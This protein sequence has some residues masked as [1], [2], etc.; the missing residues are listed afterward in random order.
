MRRYL[1]SNLLQIISNSILS[2]VFIPAFCFF[3]GHLLF[4]KNLDI[5]SLKF[6]VACVTLWI[7]SIIVISLINRVAKNCIFFEQDK[8]QYKNKTRYADSISIKY[9]Q[10]HVSIFVPNLVIPK[11]YINAN[12]FS[13]TCYL[14]KRD[15]KK[16]EKL[17]FKITRI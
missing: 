2:L 17:N 15:V 4:H 5:T 7:L 12:D 11:L 13:A 10:F 8:I 6:I 3:V 1:Y 14:S 16:L 9:F